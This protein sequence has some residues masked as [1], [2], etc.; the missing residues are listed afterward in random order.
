MTAI[1]WNDKQQRNIFIID[2]FFNVFEK[3][4]RSTPSDGRTKYFPERFFFKKVTQSTPAN[5]IL[6]MIRKTDWLIWFINSVSIK[7]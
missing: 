2:I 1:K 7:R 3:V 5:G 4:S 6:K